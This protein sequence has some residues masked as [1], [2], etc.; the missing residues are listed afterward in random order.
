MEAQVLVCNSYTIDSLFSEGDLGGIFESPF[1][2]F[3]GKGMKK[4][5][6]YHYLFFNYK[7]YT[8]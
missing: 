8:Y 3:W 5:A 7:S 1:Y 6:F 4:I 2:F